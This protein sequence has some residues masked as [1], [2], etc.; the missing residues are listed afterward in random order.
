MD[1]YFAIKNGITYKEE[2]WK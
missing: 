2:Y 1:F